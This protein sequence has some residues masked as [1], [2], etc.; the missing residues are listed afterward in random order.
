M[1]TGGMVYAAHDATYEYLLVRCDDDDMRYSNPVGSNWANDC[2]E[3]YIDPSNDGGSTAISDSTSDI[4]LVIDANNQKNV[5]MC[6]S[7][8]ATQILN[9]VTS[10]VQR[11]SSGWWLEARIQKSALDPDLPAGG[12]FGVD[13]N[14]RD[15]DNN[16]DAA[17]TTVYTWNDSSGIGFPSKIPDNWGDAFQAAPGEAPYA[18]VIDLPGTI[19]AENYDLGGEGVG[20][21]DTDAP[22]NGGAYRTDGVDIETTADTGG[23]YN[24]GWIE[25]GEWLNYMV[26]VTS[27]RNYDLNMRVAGTG[28]SFHINI[29]GQDVT[30]SRNVTSTGGWQTWAT[31]T[32]SGIN[33][34]AGQHILSIVVDSSGF[35]LNY[36]D[37][38]IPPV[39]WNTLGAVRNIG[40]GQMPCV[41]LDSTGNIHTVYLS[42]SGLQYKKYDA[43]WT[44]L[45]SET[46]TSPSGGA[47]WPNIMC[48]SNSV[49]HVVFSEAVNPT[50]P[51]ASTCYY[52]NRIGGSWK[53]PITAFVAGSG[54]SIWNIDLGLWGNYAYI[55]CQ[56]GQGGSLIG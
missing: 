3:F 17:L 18:G 37:V 22:N 21:H 10:G 25:P 56:F 29:D 52:T 6:T 50:M 2:V 4:Q 8:Y 39:Y 20:Y 46:I 13:F 24:V 40:S 42:G 14:F 53:A 31:Q 7:G 19:Q 1:P 15:N 27:T 33:L 12:T 30:G 9:G 41:A 32:V 28:G 26:N 48:D 45:L 11:D 51:Y 43:F 16:N 54:N 23:G 35:N 5:Y 47:Y 36:V 44:L 38:V 55:G 34:T 49:P